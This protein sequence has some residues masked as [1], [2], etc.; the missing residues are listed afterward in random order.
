M[1]FVCNLKLGSGKDDL[2]GDFIGDAEERLT[3]LLVGDIDG[4]GSITR[5]KTSR[6]LAAWLFSGKRCERGD[7]QN[8]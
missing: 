5:E 6:A 3:G 1:L 8:K 4:T 2:E 7:R